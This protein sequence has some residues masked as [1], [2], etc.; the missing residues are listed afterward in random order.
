[1]SDVNRL[2]HWDR[3]RY[4][5]EV[6]YPDGGDYG[7][8]ERVQAWWNT[9]NGLAYANTKMKIVDNHIGVEDT[10]DDGTDVDGDFDQREYTGT[11][12]DDQQQTMLC[13]IE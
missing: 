7:F 11:K 13:L 6:P 5:R 2:V 10:D 8:D 12:R 1:M 9:V 3:E 4:Q